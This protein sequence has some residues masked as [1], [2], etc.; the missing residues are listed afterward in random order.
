ME[1]GET[2]LT[3]SSPLAR[4]AFNTTSCGT[5]TN[6]KDQYN[7]NDKIMITVII[8][9]IIIPPL[10][11]HQQAGKISKSLQHVIKEQ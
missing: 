11:A 9:F 2:F 8:I 1:K 7:D 5:S 6:W 4:Q 3:V 10:A